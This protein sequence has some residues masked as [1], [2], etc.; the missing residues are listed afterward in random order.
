M[1]RLMPPGIVKLVAPRCGHS[2]TLLEDGRVLVAGGGRRISAERDEVCDFDDPCSL[3]SAEILDPGAMISLPVAPMPGPREQHRAAAI[4]GGALVVG[5]MLS[6]GAC[7]R[8]LSTAVRWDGA[9][10]AWHD[11][12]RVGGALALSLTSLPDGQVLVAGGMEGEIGAAAQRWSPRR[13]AW[14]RAAS[15]GRPR[16]AHGAAALSDG[17]VLVAGGLTSGP[18]GGLVT[19]GS[20][21]VYDPEADAW[22]DTG[23]LHA[24]RTELSLTALPGG[25][26]LAIGGYADDE[27]LFDDAELW[28]PVTGRWSRLGPLRHG[29]TCHTATRLLD[30]RVLVLGGMA[31]YFP[32]R[33]EPRPACVDAEVF[34]PATGRF[35]VVPGLATPRWGHTA[36]LLGDGRVLVIGG[37]GERGMLDTAEAWTG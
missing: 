36:T 34:D 29:R 21:E 13:G 4:P 14:G 1:N 22:T 28:D 12:S 27:R 23:A 7:V 5:G 15:L 17:R 16:Y 10:G 26:A 8:P 24:A 33:A 32:P 6:G 35:T 11:A 31:G 37:D 30:G 18:D 3:A 9:S 19:L 20:A 25:A 2:A